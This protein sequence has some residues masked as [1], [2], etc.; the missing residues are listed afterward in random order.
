MKHKAMLAVV[1]GIAG[2]L[3]L[4]QSPSVDSTSLTKL[5]EQA[6]GLTSKAQAAG[7]NASIKLNEYPNHFTMISLRMKSGG[8]ELHEN[9]ADFFIVV[10]GK[11]TLIS[12]G[13]LEDPQP[14][15]K[16]EMRGKSVLGGSRQ[17]LKEGDVVHIPAGV[18]HQLILADGDTF[19]YYVIKVKEK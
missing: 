7:G 10:Q 12:G 15:G 3:G 18:P 14:G 4:A 11:A 19:S 2:Q 8:G 13:K 5:A 16:G 6:K 17:E 9:N 1:L